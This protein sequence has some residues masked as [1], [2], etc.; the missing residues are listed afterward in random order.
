M[1]QLEDT[2]QEKGVT[3][4]TIIMMMLTIT[5]LFH[6]TNPGEQDPCTEQEV[7]LRGIFLHILRII[8]PWNMTQEPIPYQGQEDHT[9]ILEIMDMTRE[10]TLILGMVVIE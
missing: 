7:F 2:D 5:D 8:I 1:I 6:M 9:V 10:L 4:M 3:L